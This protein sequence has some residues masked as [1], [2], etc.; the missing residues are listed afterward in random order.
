MPAR[1]KPAAL[2]AYLE[3]FLAGLEAQALAGEDLDRVKI[4]QEV[5]AKHRQLIDIDA[6]LKEH[7]DARDRFERVWR[8]VTMGLEDATINAARKGKASATTLLRGMG[9]ITPGGGSGGS[10]NGRLQLPREHRGKADRA[11]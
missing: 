4:L 3:D 11:W 8:R 10:G 1:K 7:P 6:E 2:P 9:A 5:E